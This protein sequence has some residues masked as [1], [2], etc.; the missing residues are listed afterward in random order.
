MVSGADDGERGAKSRGRIL[1][2]QAAL[3]LSGERER[4]R[5]GAAD[6]WEKLAKGARRAP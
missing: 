2:R 6:E 4:G 3:S 5:D 1:V